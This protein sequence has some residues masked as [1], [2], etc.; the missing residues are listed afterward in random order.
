MKLTILFLFLLVLLTACG[1]DEDVGGRLPMV[2]TQWDDDTDGDVLSWFIQGEYA[3]SQAPETVDIARIGDDFPVPRAIVA[4]MLALAVTCQQTIE[5]WA[6]YPSI[7]F[8][9]VSPQ[10]WY[11]MYVNAVYTLGKM[12]G[13]GET[14]RPADMLTLYEAG[15]LIS[16]LNPGGPGLL[17]TEENRRIHISYA[18]WVDL[19]VQYIADINE[20]DSITT[21][22]IIPIAHNAAAERITTNTGPFS[23]TGINMGVY[24]DKE[25]KI[26]HRGGEVLAIL[27]QV[28]PRPT[29]HNV[30]VQNA[31]AFGLTVFIGGAVRNYVF[32]EGVTPLPEGTLIADITVY[33]NTILAA[34]PAEAVIRGTLEQVG[35][36]SIVFREW[37]AV[38]V[39]PQFSVYSLLDGA[40]IARSAADLIVGTDMADFHMTGGAVG[41]AI[42]TSKPPP[43][44]IRILIGTSNFA[45]LVHNNVSITATGPFTVQGSRN[46]EVLSPGNVGDL[47]PAQGGRNHDGIQLAAGEIFAAPKDLMGHSRLYIQPL[48]PDD[49]LEIIGLARNQ[50]TP[51]YRGI[52][53]IAHADGGF[54]IVNEL[55][56]EEYLYSVVPS[57]MP[58]HFGLEAAKVQAITA[59]TFAIHQFYENRFRAF[60]A[61][62]DDS[63]ISQ[64]YNN[65]P[66]NE[67]SIAAVRATAGLVLTYNGEVIR[68]NYYS[69]S[70][71]VTA[72]FGEVWAMGSAFPA[73]TPPYLA[74]RLQFDPNDIPDSDIRSA[75]RD[76]SQEENAALFFSTT[77]IPAFERHLPW[78]RWQVRM[79]ADE[80][81][82]SVNA[83]L[84][85]R[86]QATPGMIHTLDSAGV[87]TGRPAGNIGQVTD[88]EVT[89]RGQGGNAMEVLITG[90]VGQVRVQT[91]FN[92]RS[93]LAPQSATIIREN[94]SP[95]NGLSLLPSG[96]F[97]VQKETDTNGNL[98]AVV[99]HGGGHGH[100]VGMSQNGANELLKLGYSYREVLMHFYPGVEIERLGM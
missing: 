2:V 60:G 72:N 28:T 85:L 88:L 21:A 83:A 92:I 15:L 34:T 97:T 13:S 87:T 76:L 17:V 16:A 61:H 62:V 46:A 48:N 7:N 20:A 70:A 45:G 65:I 41:A 49:R 30:L 14:F 58:T 40:V 50:S 31:D 57:E 42:I 8:T 69:T 64:V 56:L 12:S 32:G 23:T 59:R 98:I 9:D 81:S 63:V 5:A 55:P 71:G 43:V 11:F 51:L 53:E 10:N 84:P 29:L 77:D 95:V 66:E 1:R 47:P 19:F 26:L 79:T 99:F 78:F 68:A 36:R 67:T 38:P 93:L 27:G 37:G 33:D 3:E 22:Q 82:S 54:I 52:L 25:I 89:R 100:G 4:K 35:H 80:L 94:G 86:Q 74:S 44:D 18:L 96:F 91:E 24:L 73:R 6:R 90:T 39:R 75:V